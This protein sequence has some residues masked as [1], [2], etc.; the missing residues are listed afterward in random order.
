LRL[1]SFNSEIID[2]AFDELG[3]TPRLCFETAFNQ[4][5]WKCYIGAVDD[6]LG[7]LTLESL[8]RWLH[9]AINMAMDTTSHK[10]F[11]VRHEDI[12]NVD[13][14]VCITPITPFIQSKLAIALRDYDSRDQTKLNFCSHLFL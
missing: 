10:L 8:R 7:E 3:P 9:G 2:R 12:D 1:S 14:G 5:D 6:A 13:S 11:L 4:S